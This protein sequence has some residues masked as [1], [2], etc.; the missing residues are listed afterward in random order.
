MDNISVRVVIPDNIKGE[1]LRLFH[2]LSQCTSLIRKHC[3]QLQTQKNPYTD[4]FIK[5]TNKH[6]MYQR[7]KDR[8]QRRI[9][10]LGHSILIK[11]D[12]CTKQV[13][14]F[15]GNENHNG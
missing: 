7:M 5:D 6:A 15:T 12:D 10:R 4:I 9:A 14:G 8:L 1:Y 3:L 2:K 13:F 11:S